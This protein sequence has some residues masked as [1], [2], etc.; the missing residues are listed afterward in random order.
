MT[1]KDHAAHAEE[2]LI[3][4]KMLAREQLEQYKTK[5]REVLSRPPVIIGICVAAVGVGWLVFRRRHTV[6][7]R[8]KTAADAATVSLRQQTMQMIRTIREF[9]PWITLGLATLKRMQTKSAEKGARE[10]V[11]KQ[12]DMTLH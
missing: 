3:Q 4:R 8:A 9:W 12:N 5:T 1:I 11:E 2:R 7:R 6:A 10:A